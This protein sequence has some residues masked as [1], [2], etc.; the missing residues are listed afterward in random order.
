MTTFAE[1]AAPRGAD[2]AASPVGPA[3]AA[4]GG[5]A[6]GMTCLWMGSLVLGLQL[7]LVGAS[8]WWLRRQPP[9]APPPSRSSDAAEGVPPAAAPAPRSWA[10]TDAELEA[11]ERR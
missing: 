5:E 11:L 9:T 6:G 2:G 8:L 1:D 10:M 7:L 4:N 3:R